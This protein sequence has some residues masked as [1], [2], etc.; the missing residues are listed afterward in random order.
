[1]LSQSN[2]NIFMPIG[3]TM[4]A[5]KRQK[6]NFEAS[7]ER[8]IALL[9]LSG[10]DAALKMGVPLPNLAPVLGILLPLPLPLKQSRSSRQHGPGH[11]SKRGR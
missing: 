11:N 8:G 1:M 9:A 3:L 10:L 7:F 5:A 2:V 6:N 4:P